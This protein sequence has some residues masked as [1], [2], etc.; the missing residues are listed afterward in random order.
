MSRIKDHD[1]SE[2]YR[3][4]PTAPSAGAPITNVSVKSAL[5]VLK[6]FEYFLEIRR[7]ARAKEIAREIGMPQSSTSVLL[8][9]LR[10]SGY[11][12]L[13]EA[14]RT[15]LPTPR[16]TFLGAW[17]DSGPI[18]DG[19]LVHA[20]E[21][22]AAETSAATCV[23]T[24][25]GIFSVYIYVIPGRTPM[26]FHIPV[27]SRRLLAHSA[28]GFALLAGSSDEEIAAIV[29][30]TN[31]E[32]S[33][34]VLDRASVLEQVATVR[35]DGYA[36]SRGLV[37]R[38][39]GAIA[40]PLPQGVDR[41]NRPLVVSQSGMLDDFIQNEADIVAAMRRAVARMARG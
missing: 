38:G 37:T 11:L 10:D 3:G 27:G 13:D 6:I 24:R 1:E 14:D 4:I 41:G 39:A 23:A 33:G 29:R 18:R 35:R 16:V 19:R 20:L 5:R 21:E 2:G 9:S 36:F 15:Y 26:R 32:I 34:S 31:A 7:P 28:T 22:L 30:R 40:M 17:L 25:I 12:E 8:R